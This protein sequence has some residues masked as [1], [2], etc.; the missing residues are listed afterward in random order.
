MVVHLVDEVRPAEDCVS[1]LDSQVN[2]GCTAEQVN[3]HL[4]SV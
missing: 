1:E 3:I 2:L 4:I